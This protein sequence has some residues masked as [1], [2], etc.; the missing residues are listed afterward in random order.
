M[1]TCIRNA[2]IFVGD[3]DANVTFKL[4]R[5]LFEES[6]KSEYIPAEERL[7]YGNGQYG[8]LA[9]LHILLGPLPVKRWIGVYTFQ[10]NEKSWNPVFDFPDLAAWLSTQLQASTLGIYTHDSYMLKLEYYE[11]GKLIDRFDNDELPESS[12]GH[13][14]LWQRLVASDALTHSLQEV[15][16]RGARLFADGVLAQMAEILGLELAVAGYEDVADLDN[17]IF[18]RL[19]FNRVLPES[20]SHDVVLRRRGMKR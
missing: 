12:D 13:P 9:D 17:L 6:L 5:S 20:K 16:L 1:G 7:S 10:P 19:T 11:R 18:E 8:V 4:T 15:W 3:R 14:N 2:Q